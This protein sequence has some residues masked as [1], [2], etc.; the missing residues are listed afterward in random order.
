LPCLSGRSRWR[1]FE[2]GLHDVAEQTVLDR[3]ILEVEVTVERARRRF[4]DEQ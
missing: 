2:N 3:D 4:G 1:L